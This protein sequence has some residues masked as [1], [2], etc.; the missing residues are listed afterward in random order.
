MY[1]QTTKCLNFNQQI[2]VLAVTIFHEHDCKIG[3][4]NHALILYIVQSTRVL[5]PVLQVIY[6][7]FITLCASVQPG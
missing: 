7:T 4:L 5:V 6:T 1:V 3:Q 2:T